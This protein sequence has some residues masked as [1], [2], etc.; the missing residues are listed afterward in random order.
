MQ[1]EL[2]PL[3]QK[4]LRKRTIRTGVYKKRNTMILQLLEKFS[5]EKSG[6]FQPRIVWGAVLPTDRIQLVAN[7]ASL[8][9]N[10]IHSRKRAMDE[11]GVKDP[12]AEFAHWMEE[13]KEIRRSDQLTV[14]SKQ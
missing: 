3:I 1:I 11:V 14:N 7:E 6:D 8:V 4:V 2:Y 12:E 10:G 13:Q 5:G 9:T